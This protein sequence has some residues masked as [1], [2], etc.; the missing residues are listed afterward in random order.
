MCEA[1]NSQWNPQHIPWPRS[2]ERILTIQA[3]CA[4]WLSEP[5][6]HPPQ[7]KKQFRENQPLV[8]TCCGIVDYNRSHSHPQT[9]W[10]THTDR[11]QLNWFFLSVLWS[12]VDWPPTLQPEPP[13]PWDAPT[14]TW[15]FALQPLFGLER[16]YFCMAVENSKTNHVER[17]FNGSLLSY[18]HSNVGMYR[19]W[20][21][22]EEEKPGWG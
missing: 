3:G 18:L 16:F 14:T 4:F 15:S 11:K 7:S 17:R 10:H 5:L 9:P 1:N 19:I 2:Q 6:Q 13:P 12:T 21:S 22:S 8:M 20:T